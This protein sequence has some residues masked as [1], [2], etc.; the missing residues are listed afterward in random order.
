MGMLNKYI[1]YKDMK[2]V[3]AYPV[4]FR[5]NFFTRKYRWRVRA[6]NGR[7]IGASTQGYKNFDDAAYNVASL[8]KSLV[9]AAHVLNS[10]KDLK[11]Q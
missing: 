9:E 6:D 11:K 4:K 3:I 8:G 2:R 5:R 10:T 1:K 7:I